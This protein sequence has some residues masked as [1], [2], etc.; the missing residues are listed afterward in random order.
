M[1]KEINK[2][3]H[4]LRFVFETQG[5]IQRNELFLEYLKNDSLFRKI[6]EYTYDNAKV[7]NYSKVENY[8]NK[9]FIQDPKTKKNTIKRIFDILDEL[10]EHNQDFLNTK[11][12]LDDLANQLEYGVLLVNKILNKNLDAYISQGVVNKVYKG[13]ITPEIKHREVTL[14]DIKFMQYPGFLYNKTAFNG[15]F[16]GI[17]IHNDKITC[18]DKKYNQINLNYSLILDEIKS[19]F[20]DQDCILLCSLKIKDFRSNKIKKLIQ[21]NNNLIPSSKISINEIIPFDDFKKE[22]T[23]IYHKTMML[24][25][26]RNKF[27]HFLITPEYKIV[28]SYKEAL[29]LSDGIKTVLVGCNSMWRNSKIHSRYNIDK[30]NHCILKVRTVKDNKDFVYLNCCSSDKLINSKI[31]CWKSEFDLDFKELK[32]IK[33]RF[34]KLTK[35]KYTNQIWLIA[36]SLLHG[37][38][39]DVEDYLSV[40]IR[41]GEIVNNDLENGGV[42][43]LRKR[44]KQRKVRAYKKL[45]E[46]NGNK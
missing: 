11:T 28:Y 24:D 44:K 4:Y 37:V 8:K 1:L 19:V 22:K 15:M 34:Y 10:T 21:N 40:K 13:L 2:K 30:I 16:L 7:Y 26:I 14:V 36:P 3:I 29:D 46:L 25:P 12:N 18:F 42:N 32:N 39:N 5:Y 27:K 35:N 33:V 6:I 45:R 23:N 31:L 41:S 38:D 9:I 17:H 20:Y 43:W